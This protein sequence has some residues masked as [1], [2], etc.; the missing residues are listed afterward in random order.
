MG[1]VGA[2][3]LKAAATAL[4]WSTNIWSCEVYTVDP[5]EVTVTCSTARAKNFFAFSLRALTSLTD[6]SSVPTSSVR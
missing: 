5:G 2:N 6:I 3:A 4:L 1:S